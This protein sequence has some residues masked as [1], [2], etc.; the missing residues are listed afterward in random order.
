M[1]HC[2]LGKCM[3]YTAPLLV[4]SLSMYIYIYICNGP[5]RLYHHVLADETNLFS[6]PSL[7]GVDMCNASDRQ[8]N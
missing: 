4:Y 2:E 6:E 5:E 7:L 1:R 3:Q 8:D